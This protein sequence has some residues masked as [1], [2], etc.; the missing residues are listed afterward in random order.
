MRSATVATAAIA[1]LRRFFMATSYGWLHAQCAHAPG[2]NSRYESERLGSKRGGPNL[3]L[4]SHFRRS[5]Q[6]THFP[7]PTSASVGL[8]LASRSPPERHGNRVSRL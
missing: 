4:G 1:A 7:S 3:K 8:H 6:E 5:A 2:V